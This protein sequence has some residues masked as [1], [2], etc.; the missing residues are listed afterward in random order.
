MEG[1]SLFYLLSSSRRLPSVSSH[2]REIC[3]WVLIYKDAWVTA[4]KGNVMSCTELHARPQRE[5]PLSIR[6]QKGVRG[7][8]KPQPLLGF[9]WEA[10][11]GRANNSG[12]ASLNS[13]GGL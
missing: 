5:A 1:L 10:R 2:G 8:Q 12:L 6:R 7:R 9:P 13:S 11:Q 3:A 4:W